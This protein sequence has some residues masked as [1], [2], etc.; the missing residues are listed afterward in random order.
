M[1]AQAVSLTDAEDEV[2]QDDPPP[3]LAIANRIPDPAAAEITVSWLDQQ[4]CLHVRINASAVAGL[5]M[6]RKHHGE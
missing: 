2:Q 5:Y 3:V 4:S 6:P 1:V